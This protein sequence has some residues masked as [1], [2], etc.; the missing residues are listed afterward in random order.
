MFY[1]NDGQQ[2]WNLIARATFGEATPAEL[3]LLQQL[4]QNDSLLQQ[5][6]DF[7]TQVLKSTPEI[8]QTGEEE[9]QMILEKARS[10]TKYAQQLKPVKKLWKFWLAAASVAAII[11]SG[12]FFTRPQYNTQITLP[13][14]KTALASKNGERNEMILP[15]G[16]KVWLNAGSQLFYVNDFKGKTREVR[17]E[18]EAYFDIQKNAQK[19][20]I[21]HANT[22]D[23]KVLGT[24]FNVKAY[25]DDI[26]IET[27]LFRGLVNIT[28]RGEANFQPILLYPNQKAIIPKENPVLNAVQPEVS[29]DVEAKKSI[30]IQ[31]IDSSKTEAKQIDVA[32]K[33]NRLEFKGNDFIELAGRLERW[34]NVKIIFEDEAVKQ[35]HF[36]GSFENESIQQ[37]LKAMQIANPFIFKINNDEIQIKSAR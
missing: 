35:L 1:L 2:I 16:S 24:A 15:D 34:Y 17:L 30:V 23:I 4:L 33:F 8:Q 32:W 37:A 3:A 27:T 31:Q 26:N 20:F 25:A 7:L 12:W 9:V 36:S 29:R 28:R 5:K 14:E 13:V 6:F 18:G 19:P 10:K 11:F 22:I 21:V